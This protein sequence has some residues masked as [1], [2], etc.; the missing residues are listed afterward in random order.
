MVRCFETATLDTEIDRS[1]FCDSA[2]TNM[3]LPS[4][5][6]TMVIV[7]SVVIYAEAMPASE[8]SYSIITIRFNDTTC[9]IENGVLSISGQVVGN[10]TDDQKQELKEYIVQTQRWYNQL[11]RKI[12]EIFKHFFESI[13]KVWDG[14]WISRSE[15][16]IP[17]NIITDKLEDKK[18][19]DDFSLFG[20][21]KPPSFC[22]VKKCSKPIP[23]SRTFMIAVETFGSLWQDQ[24]LKNCRISNHLCMVRSQQ[25]RIRYNLSI[26]HA[27]EEKK[28]L[29]E[30]RMCLHAN[31]KHRLISSITKLLND[32]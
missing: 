15:M 23:Y 21:L 18:H 2:G 6:Y 3:I 1:C 27:M 22:E 4:I 26:L 28:L 31:E 29:Q 10:L 30:T 12:E 20:D 9:K 17:D 16:S 5:F 32:M 14:A 8:S 24:Q 25:N 7:A 13:K 11:H 19:S